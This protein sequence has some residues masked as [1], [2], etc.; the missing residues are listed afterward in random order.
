MPLTLRFKIPDAFAGKDISRKLA[1]NVDKALSANAIEIAGKARQ[2]APKDM[3]G[4]AGSI[5]EDVSKF[6]QKAVKVNSFYAS[7]VEFG[8]GRYAAKYVA[9][10]PPDWR[11]Y[12]ATFKGKTEGGGSLDDFLLLMVEWVKRKGLHGRTKSGNRRTGK[13]ANEDA[14][15][16]AYVIV[17]SILRNGIHPH[18]FLVPA[19]EDQRKQL[20]A[21]ISA[22]I[23]KTFRT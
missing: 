3:G 13:K 23:Q 2:L 5:A 12:A 8:T 22:A 15:N 1:N 21:D 18:P 9:T 10:L 11:T 19:F 4:L 6:L 16:I 17:I 14:Y 20:K 7:Y